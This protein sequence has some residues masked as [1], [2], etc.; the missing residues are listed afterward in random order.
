[1]PLPPT[2][3]SLVSGVVQTSL[4][5]GTVVIGAVDQGSPNNGG[6]D[7]WPTEDV[8]SAAILAALVSMQAS[9]TSMNAILVDVHN[10]VKHTLNTTV[11]P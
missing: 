4:T 9:L 6:A 11:V 7:A 5:G 3:A 10:A 2:V 1:M 8:N